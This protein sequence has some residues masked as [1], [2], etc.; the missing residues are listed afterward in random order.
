M[1]HTFEPIEVKENWHVTWF[2]EYSSL[3][4]PLGPPQQLERG[5]GPM[6]IL[7]L[8]PFIYFE[9]KNNVAIEINYWFHIF[10]F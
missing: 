2:Y 10:I 1:H 3:Q 7:A 6:G 4:L 9:G 5:K 8:G